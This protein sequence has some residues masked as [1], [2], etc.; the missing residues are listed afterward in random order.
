M[1]VKNLQKQIVAFMNRWGTA[2]RSPSTKETLFVHLVEEVGELA[3]QYVNKVSRK[4]QYDEHEV[5]N[6]IGD[7]MM[8]LVNLADLHGFDVEDVVLEIFREDEP[9][10]RAEE[11]RL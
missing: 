8:Q 1:E 3:R 4:A 6:A 7:I 9:R 5:K 2:R 11:K 10:L